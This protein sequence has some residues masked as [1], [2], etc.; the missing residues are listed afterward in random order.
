MSRSVKGSKGCG[1]DYWSRRPYSSSWGYGPDVKNLC[2]R[3]ERIQA[4]NE[5]LNQLDEME[6]KDN[7]DLMEHDQDDMD[8]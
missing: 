4:K 1:Y 5:I 7:H 2:H 8:Y 6:E 3:A